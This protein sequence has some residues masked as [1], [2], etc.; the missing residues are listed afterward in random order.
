MPVREMGD[1]SE[2]GSIPEGAQRGRVRSSVRERGAVPHGAGQVAV[3]RRLRLPHCGGRRHSEIKTRALYQC[4]ACR[5]QTSLIAGTIFAATKFDE[6]VNSKKVVGRS[7]GGS[8]SGQRGA[9]VRSQRDRRIH[10]HHRLSRPQRLFTA[11]ITGNIV[12]LATHIVAGHPTIFSYSLS[13]PAFML[14]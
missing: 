7:L 11:H 5:R 4:T 10:G 8:C 9:A 6:I 13:C 12:V 1:G 3:A 14:L 2:Q